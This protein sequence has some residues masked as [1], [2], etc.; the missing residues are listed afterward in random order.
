MLMGVVKLCSR[1]DGVLES[2]RRMFE[3]TPCRCAPL[4]VVQVFH[5]NGVIKLVKQV[6]MAL[7][8]ESLSKAVFLLV[9]T[10]YITVFTSDEVK[11]EGLCKNLA[12]RVLFTTSMPKFPDC[13]AL[14]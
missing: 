6:A 4:G 12:S 2:G 3:D 7:T 14:S 8:W 1:A 10:D 9:M 11:G 5:M 13:G